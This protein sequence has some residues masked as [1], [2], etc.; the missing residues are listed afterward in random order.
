M[1]RGI[2]LYAHNNPALDYALMAVISGGLAK[3]HLGVPA[4]LITDASTVEWMKQSKIYNK[5]KNLFEHIIATDRPQTNNMRRLHDG[6]TNKV[7]PFVNSNRC[8]AWDLTPYDRTLLIDSDFL[9]FSKRLG[10]YWNIDKDLMI[11]ES[12]NDI[13]DNPRLGYHDRY[14]SDVGIKLYWAT[15]VMFTKNENTEMFFNLVNYIK[16]N[17]GYFA[18]VYRFDSRQYRNDIAFSVAKH[19]IDGFE[20]SYTGRLPP[21][22]TLQDRDILHSVDADKLTVLISPKFDSNYCAAS[23]SNIDIHVMNKQSVVRNSDRLLEL[24]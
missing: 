3:K 21:I 13:Y 19:I 11:A 6:E 22:L 7:I 5:A 4:S 10:E 9:I 20:E 8:S 2:L 23:F 15:T 14:V 1:N 12:A 18:D 17:Y 16:D 24:I